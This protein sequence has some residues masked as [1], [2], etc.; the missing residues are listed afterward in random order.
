MF[1]HLNI[2]NKIIA[3]DSKNTI[4]NNLIINKIENG[5]IKQTG[6]YNLF[7]YE[8]CIRNKFDA[9]FTTAW[10]KINENYNKIQSAGI[11]VIYTVDWQEN[12]ALGRAEWIKFV[13]A[14]FNKEKTADSIFSI[15]ERNYNNIKTIA[16]KQ[17]SKPILING[18]IYNGIW[19][20]AGGKS[21]IAHL[22]SDAGALYPFSNTNNTGSIPLNIE[23]VYLKAENADFWFTSTLPGNTTNLI[24]NEKLK[25]IKAVK[26]NNIYLNIKKINKFGGNDYWETG[27]VRP[28]FIL[29]DIVKIIHPNLF[30]DY[31]LKYYIHYEKTLKKLKK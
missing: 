13:S 19:Y 28:D 18:N 22:F 11:P 10:D 30:P 29:K 25:N 23:N 20:V 27:S 12:T 6:A 5:K 9:V 7:N 2:L 8:T 17:Q 31:K 14:F 4:Y 16:K 24:K 21:Y 1:E 26:N 3:V 15:I